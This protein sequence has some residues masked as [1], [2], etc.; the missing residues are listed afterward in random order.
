MELVCQM[1]GRLG[2]SRPSFPH[3][4]I[5]KNKRLAKNNFIVAMEN[6][7]RST[8]PRHAIKKKPHGERSETSWSF[9]LH[10]PHHV[11]SM[12]QRDLREE[13]V[14]FQFPPLNQKEHSGLYL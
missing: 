5:K 8:A 13:A 1:H 2:S 6:S 11:P 10:L 4:N 12:A 14:Q 9:Y 3:G 7:E